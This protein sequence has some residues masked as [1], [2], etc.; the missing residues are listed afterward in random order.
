MKLRVL[1]SVCQRPEEEIVSIVQL[2][3]S[4]SQSTIYRPCN[5]LNDIWMSKIYGHQKY[6]WK[7]YITICH[8][9]M[10]G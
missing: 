5:F 10:T 2:S 1:I 4:S 9:A 6:T 7:S 8:L 3:I